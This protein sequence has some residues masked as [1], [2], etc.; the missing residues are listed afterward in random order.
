MFVGM[1]QRAN[2]IRQTPEFYHTLTSNCTNNIVYHTNMVL[3]DPISAWQRGVV[4]PGYSD[5]LAYQLGIIDTD[6][7][8]EEAR[9]KFRIDQHVK[10]YDGKGNFSEFIRA[11]EVETDTQ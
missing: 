11:A 5:W 8:L 6:L 10:A 1:L 3:E 4:F 9:E 7:S 2:A